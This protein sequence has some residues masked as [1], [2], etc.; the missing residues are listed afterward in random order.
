M[1]FAVTG[2]ISQLLGYGILVIMALVTGYTLWCWYGDV[3]K[4]LKHAEAT[5]AANDRLVGEIEAR[6]NEHDQLAAQ[7]R[8]SDEE[9]GALRNENEGL[10]AE[11]SDLIAPSGGTAAYPLLK[12]EELSDKHISERTVYIADFAREVA[13]LSWNDAVVKNRTFEECYIIGPAVL[14]PMNTGDLTGPTFVGDD[15]WWE[16]GE[17][18]FW[19][20]TS[21]PIAFTGIIGLQDC[22]FRNCRYRRVGILMSEE[23]LRQWKKEA[24]ELVANQIPDEEGQESANPQ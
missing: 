7:L 8:Q 3:Q 14:V 21:D 15:Q 2:W 13:G 16:E 22:V 6:T 24:D 4:A 10:T 23:E 17:N 11:L 9:K 19:A 12:R 1:L 5:K 20:P 18:A